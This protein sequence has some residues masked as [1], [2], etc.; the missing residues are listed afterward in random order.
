LYDNP[1]GKAIMKFK[2]DYKFT[3]YERS[4]NWIR[5]SGHFS[6][7]RWQSMNQKVWVKEKFIEKIK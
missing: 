2:K 6:Q 3:A 5:V 4:G 7:K 1:N